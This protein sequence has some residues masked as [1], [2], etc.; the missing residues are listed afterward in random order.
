MSTMISPELKARFSSMAKNQKIMA[1]AGVAGFLILVNTFHSSSGGP[2]VLSMQEGAAVAAAKQLDLSPFLKCPSTNP[3]LPPPKEE[4]TTKPVWLTQFHHSMPHHL[5]ENLIN[6][7]TMTADGAKDFYISKPGLHKCVGDT[8]T[9]TCNNIHPKLP[10]DIDLMYNDFYSKYILFIRNP[11]TAIPSSHNWKLNKFH[12]LE[13]QTPE[14][15][16]G[17]TRDGWVERMWKQWKKSILEWKASKYDLG[18]YLVYEDLMDVRRG[19]K[20]LQKMAVLLQEAGFDV[21]DD[22]DAINCIWYNGIG[23][24]RL[25]VHK[26]MGQEYE[27]YIPGFRENH[28]T[29]FIDEL[30]KLIREIKGDDVLENILL[31]YKWEIDGKIR[32]DI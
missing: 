28:K 6:P 9:V 20:T 8:E 15:D 4:W 10:A 1:L 30:N 19:P 18:M 2:E 11:M 7:L 23:K 5:D 27:D 14:D 32:V 16:W 22:E 12:G 3:E 25:E 13:G 21:V 26:E 24:E 17:E 31:R 29:F